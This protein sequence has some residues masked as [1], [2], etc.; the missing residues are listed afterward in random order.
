MLHAAG[1]R[2]HRQIVRV[3]DHIQIT[4]QTNRKRGQRNALSQ[5]AAG[6]GTFDIEGWSAAGLAN[7]S[8]NF[9]TDPAQ[10]LNQPHA[11]GGFPLAQRCRGN[12]GNVNIS[13]QVVVIQPLEHSLV[14]H[15]GQVFAHGNELFALQAKFFGNLCDRLHVSFCCFGDFPIFH[16][17]RI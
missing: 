6:G 9:L 15:F 14:I 5:A 8:D 11:G 16:F 4:S 17:S 3:A 1:Q 7:R 13:A 12:S 2:H 10:P